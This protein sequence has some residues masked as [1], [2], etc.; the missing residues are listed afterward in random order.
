VDR[1]K[2]AGGTLGAYPEFARPINIR[3]RT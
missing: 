3:G 1:E 2:P